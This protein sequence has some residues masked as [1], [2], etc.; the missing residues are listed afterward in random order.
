MEEVVKQLIPLIS[1]GPDW[2]YALVQ[3]NGDACHAPSP[4][5]EHLS[6]MV[7]GS[8]SSVNCRRISQLEVHQLFSLGSQVIYPAGFNGCE[9]PM[10]ISLPKSL[11]NGTTMLR[12]GPISLPMTIPQ[13]TMMGQEPKALYLGGHSIS[14]PTASPIR[15]PPPNSEGQVSMTME[16]RNSYPRQY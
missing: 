1:A 10:I 4:M 6:I 11:A 3:L 14:I 15:A 8:T 2:S 13:S 9:V 5:E 16:V 7:K 12:G